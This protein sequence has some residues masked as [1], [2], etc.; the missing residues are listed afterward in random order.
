MKTLLSNISEK[1]KDSLVK[2]LILPVMEMFY[3][4]Q[5]EGTHTGESAFFIRIGGCDVGCHWCDEKESWN[6]ELHPLLTINDIIN[7]IPAISSKS[8]VITGGE[9]LQFNLT[10]LCDALHS[11]GFML[12]LETSG[13]MPLSGKWEWICLS[14]K[15]NAPPLQDIYQTANELKIIIANEDDFAWAEY[16]ANKVNMSCR[17]FLQPEWSNQK[18][19]IPLLVKYILQNSKWNLSL[20]M[21]KYIGIP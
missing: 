12:F 6:P 3:S 2:G 5:G 15:Q 11:Q 14:P 19:I 1:Q 20:Q 8:I 17:L 10:S 4:L 7:T 21:H 18:K 16:N 9:P 13:F